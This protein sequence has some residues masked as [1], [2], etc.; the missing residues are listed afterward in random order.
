[1]NSPLDLIDIRPIRMREN[2]R[3]KNCLDGPTT[4]PIDPA[5]DGL[6]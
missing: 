6:S 4:Y 3:K 2:R 1:V 5:I